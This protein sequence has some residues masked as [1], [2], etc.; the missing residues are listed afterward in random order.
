MD[1]GKKKTP[2]VAVMAELWSAQASLGSEGS[3]HTH[4]CPVRKTEIKT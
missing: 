4:Q 2:V 3:H 1:T